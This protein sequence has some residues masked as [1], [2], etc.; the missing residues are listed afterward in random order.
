MRTS[1]AESPLTSHGRSACSTTT[2]CGTASSARAGAMRQRT[3]SPSRL[4]SIQRILLGELT[5]S[6]LKGAAAQRE[7]CP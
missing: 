7:S 1:L 6:V 3:L 5:A 4:S 2:P